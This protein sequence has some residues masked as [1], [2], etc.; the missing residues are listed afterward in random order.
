MTVT[1]SFVFLPG[2]VDSPWDGKNV[3]WR[4][5]TQRTPA[6]AGWA[7]NKQLDAESLLTSHVCKF[8]AQACFIKD[9]SFS[10]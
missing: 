7:A 2:A 10:H 9:A 3:P 4:P 8:I 1:I 5:G 6:H